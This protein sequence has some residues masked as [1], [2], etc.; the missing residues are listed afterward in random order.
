MYQKITIVGNLGNKPELRFTSAGTEVTTLNVATNRKYN[1]QTETAWFSV[2][3]WGK[4]AVNC[5]QYLDKGSQVLVEG[6]LI[7]GE[8]GNPETFQRKDGSWGSSFKVSAREVK[9]LGGS[10][11]TQ[12]YDRQPETSDDIPF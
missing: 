1:D 8:D 12:S 11:Q 10:G 2:S 7:P 5:S 9:F 6:R 3:V 4:Q